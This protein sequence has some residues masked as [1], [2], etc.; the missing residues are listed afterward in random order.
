MPRLTVT[1]PSD[2]LRQ[3]RSRVGPRQTSAWVAQAIAERLDREQL[4]AAVADYE[5][6]AG[7]IN[8]QDIESA[9]QRTAWEPAGT[10]HVSPVA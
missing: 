3:M 7:S 2:L 8:E 1:L 4:V 9:K 10:R 5:A 6:E